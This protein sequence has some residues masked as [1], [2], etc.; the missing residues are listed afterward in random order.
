MLPAWAK[1][2]FLEPLRFTSAKKHGDQ[3][4]WVGKNVAFLLLP[5]LWLTHSMW[6]NM[7]QYHYTLWTC[8][9]YDWAVSGIHILLYIPNWLRENLAYLSFSW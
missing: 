5:Y 2:T 8:P 7:H 1:H 4:E 3:T 6:W 9:E